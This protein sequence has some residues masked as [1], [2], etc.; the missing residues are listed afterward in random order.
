[1]NESSWSQ[2]SAKLITGITY[3]IYILLVSV[4]LSWVSRVTDLPGTVHTGIWL[5]VV[6]YGAPDGLIRMMTRK[7]VIRWLRALLSGNTS[8]SDK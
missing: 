7:G 1:M 3:T 2:D 5:A 8:D 4:L 6:L